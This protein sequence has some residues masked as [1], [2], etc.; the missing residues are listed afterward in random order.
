MHTHT[1]ISIH[2]IF[3]ILEQIKIAFYCILRQPFWGKKIQKY[4]KK[5][6]ILVAQRDV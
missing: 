1:H 6:R 2:Y 3:L 5:G 4:K